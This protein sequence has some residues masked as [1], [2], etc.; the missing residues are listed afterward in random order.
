M[1]YLERRDDLIAGLKRRFAEASV[2]GVEGG[3]HLTWYL[4]RSAAP[5]QTLQRALLSKGVGVYSLIDGPALMLHPFDGW[6]RILLLGYPCLDRV[7]TE[8]ALD[9]IAREIGAA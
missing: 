6:D 8:E 3:M 7:K 9:C 5:A 2:L 4:P 1:V